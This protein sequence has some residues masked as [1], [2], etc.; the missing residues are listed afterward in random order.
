MT[1]LSSDNPLPA[2][3]GETIQTEN[4]YKLWEYIASNNTQSNS[5]GRWNLL[6]DLS[7]DDGGGSGGGSGGGTGADLEAL[8]F[9]GGDAI[10]SHKDPEQIIGGKPVVRV[11]T[12]L[13]IETLTTIESRP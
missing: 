11:H 5:V 9:M 10:E 1:T 2:I 7:T 6:F 3:N 8:S 13:D 4:G 12:N